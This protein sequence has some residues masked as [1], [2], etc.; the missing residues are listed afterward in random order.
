M[1][2]GDIVL[3]TGGSSGVGLQLA[4]DL[5]QRGCKVLI[6][7]RSLEKLQQAQKEIPGIDIFQCDLSKIKDCND[8]CNRITGK[9]P[10]LN[11]LINNAA[12]VNK[13]DFRTD[14]S[15]IPKAVEEFNTNIMAPIRL[16]K[17]LLPVIESNK[18]P[19][20]I[21]ISTGLIYAPREIYPFYNATKAALHS[22]T[23][24][25]RMQL[26]KSSPVK[27]TEVIL[28]VVDT[29]WHK[30]NPPKMAMPVDKAVSEILSKLEKGQTEIRIGKVELL[31]WLSRIA[32][33]LAIKMLNRAT[34]LK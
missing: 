18:R 34:S 29:P 24:V 22:F 17:V 23:Q 15:A 33:E 28:P 6:C 30:G 32:P 3:I 7:G 31:H 5:S 20:I 16:I 9:Y 12:V 27:I 10:G 13:I 25:L 19:Q 21:N 26:R 1:Q 14:E 4:K 2:K 11:I 8:L